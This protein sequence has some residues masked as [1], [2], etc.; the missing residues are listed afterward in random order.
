MTSTGTGWATTIDP[1]LRARVGAARIEAMRETMRTAGVSSLLVTGSGNHSFLAM[2]QLWWLTGCRQLGRDAAVLLRDGHEAVLL[3]E[4]AWDAA[5]ARDEGWVAEVRGSDSVAD[6]LV[7]LGLPS[8]SRGIAGLGTASAALRAATGAYSRD[9]VDLQSELIA[10]AAA[11]DEL[12]TAS[13]ARA[14]A[15]GEAGWER[16]C[17][18]ARPGLPDYV[19]VAEADLAMRALGAQDNFL[20]MSASQHNR[21]VHAP[22]GRVLE[23]GDIVLGE[24]SPCV[25][26]YYAQICRSGVIGPVSDERHEGFALLATAFAAGLEVCRPGTPVPVVY[27]AVNAPVAAAGYEQYC[28]PPYMRSRGHTMGLGPMVPAD[29]SDRSE[30]TLAASMTF[31][32][33]PNQYLPGPGYL[34]CG[35]QVE[36]RDDGPFVFSTP[37]RELISIGG[38][39]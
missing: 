20:Y 21:A 38:A 39:L 22:T 1:G 10:L 17:E 23:E 7:A 27:A 30:V 4:P 6:A 8:G 15:I 2:N 24:I 33:H 3:V 31:V 26:G 37:Q 14:V 35:E 9:A 11:G 25:D 36:V 16:V 19:L 29:I 18:L 12:A 32:L 5:R 13:V 34:L 28:K